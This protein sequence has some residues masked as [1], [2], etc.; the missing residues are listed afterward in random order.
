MRFGAGRY[1][2]ERYRNQYALLMA[3]AWAQGLLAAM[4]GLRMF[5]PSRS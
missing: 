3:M 2:D 5:A 4:P 1:F